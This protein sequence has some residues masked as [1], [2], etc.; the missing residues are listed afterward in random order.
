MRNPDGEP[1]IAMQS[2]HVLAGIGGGAV[3]V[4]CGI[5]FVIPFLTTVLVWWL[6]SKLLTGDRKILLAAFSV[7]AGHGLW[8][9]LGML[10]AAT[11]PAVLP[12]LVLYLIG[13]VWLI[14]KPSVGPLYFLGV[15]QLLSISYNG[16]VFTTVPL[17]SAAQKA[18]IVHLIWRIAAMVL[19][20]RLF[21]T[22][23]S[24]ERKPLGSTASP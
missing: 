4:Y 17:G 8:M 16:Y 11:R 20:A 3:G 1:T 13:L 18:L 22:L 15:Y 7:Q 9:T 5:H 12:D 24:R 6:G 21:L 23:R 14:K 19:M 2:L 10:G